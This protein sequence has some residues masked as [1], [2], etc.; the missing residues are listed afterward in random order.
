MLWHSLAVVLA[1]SFKSGVV[2]DE[3][4]NSKGFAPFFEL[5]QS[6]EYK[7]VGTF[8]KPNGVWIGGKWIV[9]VA[10]GFVSESGKITPPNSIFFNLSS[11]GRK[12]VLPATRIHVPRSYMLAKIS[13]KGDGNVTHDIAVVEL[14]KE[15]Q[16]ADFKPA[17]LNSSGE[18]VG[19]R[20][21]FVGF[22]TRGIASQGANAEHYGA[23]QSWPQDKYGDRTPR[24]MAFENDVDGILFDG[25]CFSA[26]YES[27]RSIPLL[28]ITADG[29]SGGGVFARFDGETR[30]IGISHNGLPRPGSQGPTYTKGN[31]EGSSTLC[32]RV[33][34]F[35]RSIMEGRRG[36]WEEFESM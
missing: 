24:P 28:G 1:S 14:A 22:G 29:D 11:Q 18:E 5:A 33:S 36:N 9:T 27:S 32:V 26:K 4:F 17:V 7:C 6:P 30:L 15:P 19:K 12:V 3:V 34:K 21:T 31:V 35:W 20:A 25:F 8:L 23:G 2:R 16:F 10:H 13:G